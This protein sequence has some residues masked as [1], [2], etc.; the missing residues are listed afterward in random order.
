[1]VYDGN[2]RACQIVLFVK[3][4]FSSIQ[5]KQ[6]IHTRPRSMCSGEFAIAIALWLESIIACLETNGGGGNAVL[7]SQSQT[8]KWD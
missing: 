5:K 6:R 7:L 1:M 2:F 8:S 3:V 4:H